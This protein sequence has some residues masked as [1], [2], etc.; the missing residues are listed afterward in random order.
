MPHTL[1]IPLVG[2][3]QSW[4]S[5][6]RFGDR[7]THPEPT[8]SGVLG[9]VCAALGRERGE[10]MD[11]LNALRFGVR[12][13]RAGHPQT[14]YQTSKPLLGDSANAK[15]SAILSTRHYL[16]DARF[17][18]GLEGGNLALLRQIEDALKNPKW[19][20]SLGRKSYPLT[21]PP[22]LPSSCNGGSLREGVELKTSL[23]T[24]PWRYLTAR[25]GRDGTPRTLRLLLEDP[26]G[27]D[28]FLD[29]PL[30]FSERRF[31]ARRVCISFLEGKE[32]PQKEAHPC[33]I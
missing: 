2:P 22:Y 12:V 10:R 16:A 13:D 33:C 20:L 4:G 15:D 6:S 19:A 26:T 30:K 5:R 28:T 29:A 31:A 11:D 32:L 17:L 9:L 18:V 3:M 8:K 24:E 1:L 25:E 7:D 14:D 21:L 27:M 23:T